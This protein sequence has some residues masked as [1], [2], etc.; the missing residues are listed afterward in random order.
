M[1]RKVLALLLCSLLI[2]V[3]SKSY[4]AEEVKVLSYYPSPSGYY[5]LLKTKDLV[6]GEDISGHLYEG[7]KAIL[8]VYGKDQ[9]DNMYFYVQSHDPQHFISF[10]RTG[11]NQI[12]I[13]IDTVAPLQPLHIK[14]DTAGISGVLLENLSE[15]S[16]AVAGIMF[17]NKQ[18]FS[19]QTYI[20][21]NGVQNIIEARQNG[22]VIMNSRNNG[23]VLI[24]AED[25]DI[26]TDEAG[27]MVNNAQVILATDN[28]R[29]ILSE[30]EYNVEIKSTTGISPPGLVVE[31]NIISK[32]NINVAESLNANKVNVNDVLHLEPRDS[33][34]QSGTNGDLYV[35]A[36]PDSD[37]NRHIYCYL[38]DVWRQL[39]N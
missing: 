13:G 22:L 5:N 6:I 27:N 17:T 20:G 15:E 14:R 32:K 39:D 31:G 34:P 25:T 28:Y 11:L 18:P 3:F 21:L 19:S 38:D 2:A 26:P 36:L 1:R 33:A 7:G 35:G 9:S 12:N 8:E 10:A 30:A 24:K 37:G 16:N 29:L 23:S 4:A